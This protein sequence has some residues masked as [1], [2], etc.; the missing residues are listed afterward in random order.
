M[1]DQSRRPGTLWILAVVVV[2][3]AVVGGL[4]QPG[5]G[6]EQAF[7]ADSGEQA[8]GTEAGPA[9][10]VVT[11]EIQTIAP[12]SG[13]LTGGDIVTITGTDLDRVV[14]S[15]GSSPDSGVFFGGSNGVG[16]RA[17]RMIEKTAT[18]LTVIA[19]RGAAVGAA[20]VTLVTGDLLVTRQGGY[21]YLQPTITSVTPSSG[22]T[23]G[24][25]AVTIE[26]TGFGYTGR[27][28]ADSTIT[29]VTVG[30][31]PA[32]SVVRVDATTITA[33]VPAHVAATT[34]VVVTVSPSVGPQIVITGSGLFTYV[35]AP[36]APTISSVTPASGPTAGGNTVLVTGTNLRGSDT[37]PA[38][39]SFGGTT[40]TVTAVNVEKTQATVTVP[41]HAAGLVD[42]VARTSDG[43]ATLISGYE[44]GAPPTITSI[45]P[46]SGPLAG[47]TRITVTGTNFGSTGVPA[48][49]VG[50]RA[51]RCVERVSS[52]RILAV[53]PVG[54][55]GPAD[56]VVS[57]ATGGGKATR[58]G[59][60]TYVVPT[61]TPTISAITPPQGPYTG[62]TPIT[63]T[64]TNF[65]SATTPTVL[66][67]GQCAT[68]VV[69][70]SNT[71]ITAKTPAGA[72]G[73]ATLQVTTA[74][75][76]VTSNLF[77]YVSITSVSPVSG[78]TT[79]DTTITITGT[80]F[81]VSPA[82]TVGGAAATV[83][84]ASPTSIVAVTPPGT[85]GPRDVV[86]TP[87]GGV[88]ITRAEGFR[89]LAPTI[90]SVRP[91]SGLLSGGNTV[92]VT[93][94]GFGSTGTPSV[95]FGGRAATNVVRLGSTSLTATVPAGAA[96]V[97]V[98]VVVTPTRGVGSG[99]LSDGYAY[100]ALQRTP[101]I[102]DVSPDRGSQE[103]GTVV[104]VEGW[105][106]RGSND[107]PARVT[108]GGVSVL[109][110]SV[111]AD[112]RSL[113]FTAPVTTAG[114]KNLSII[115]NEGTATLFGAFASVG[116]PTISG[117]D[118]VSPRGAITYTG[119]NVITIDGSGFRDD[120]VPPP[121]VTVNGTAAVVNSSTDTRI[122][123]TIP[124]VSPGSL[125]IT[126]TPSDGP[127]TTL[128]ACI[129]LQRL[130][131]I[132]AVASPSS[133][134]YD[135]PTA[136]FSFTTA[137]LQSG[138]GVGS[139][140]FAFSGTGSTAYGPS[141]NPPTAS[142]TYEVMPSAAV[143]SSGSASNYTIVYVPA[144]YTIA[145]IGAT[146]T[147]DDKEI[148]YGDP[149]PTFTGFATG[150]EG[151]DALDEV[152]Y[153]FSGSGYGPS[154]TP[155]TNAGVYTITPSVVSL[156]P[157][158]VANYSFVP[159]VGTYT[160]AK[161]PVTVTPDSGQTKVYDGSVPDPDTLTYAIT[162][163]SL[164]GTDTLSD[165]LKV[166][167]TGVGSYEIVKSDLAD[168]S[169][170]NYDITV[171]PGVQ[172]E[173]TPRPVTVTP[174]SKTKVY[175]DADPTLT[176]TVSPS[177]SLSGAVTRTDGEAVG[178]Y[179]ITQGTLTN[180]NNPN[181]DITFTTGVNLDITKRPITITSDD[182]EIT[183]GDTLPVNG[184]SV[185]TGSLAFLDVLTSATY[186]Y[187]PLDPVDAGEYTIT[188]SEA[189]ITG[190]TGGADNYDITYVGSTLTI[191]PVIVTVTPDDNQSKVYDDV[192]PTLTYTTSTLPDGVTITGL[193][194]RDSGEDVD[195]YDFTLGTLTT[196]DGNV[197][198]ELADPSPTF[199]I[200]PLAVTVTA[201]AKTKDYGSDDPALTYSTSPTVT[202]SGSL[203]RDTGESVG[204]Y[205]ITQ[206][207]VT[208]ANN[209]NY[210][211]TFVG[212]DLTITP[213]TVTV[214]PDAGQSKVYG[215]TDPA[216]T[217]TTSPD[218]PLTGDLSR[219]TG[220]NVGTYA[221]TQ[222]TLVSTADYTITFSSGSTFEVTARPITI[223]A[224]D[225]SSTF[226][227]AL[228]GNSATVTSGTLASGDSV[229][230]LDYA[231]SPV[232]TPS[233]AGTYDITPSAAVITP[234][235]ESNYDV[236]YAD[237]TL[238]IDPAIVTV[239]PDPDQTKVFGDT[240]PTLTY[241]TSPTQSLT[242][243][244]GRD[245]GEDVGEYDFTLGT[246]SV[247]PNYELELADPSPTFGVTPLAVTV[248]ADPQTKSYGDTDPT[249]GYTTDPDVGTALSG[250][251]DRDPGED[252]GTYPITQ[253]TV[254][255]ENN[256]NYTVTFVS[257]GL[258]ITQAAVTVTPDAGQTKIYG[259]D[260]PTLT[261]VADPDV[262]LDGE[263]DRDPGEDVD[264]YD[265]TQGTIVS[266]ANYTVTFASGATFEIVPRPVT[267]TADDQEAAVGESL[268]T[269]TS[270]ITS[271]DLATGDT[272]G[273]VTYT[274]TP[275]DPAAIGTYDIVPSGATITPG[276]ASNYDITYVAGTLTI[277]TAAVTVTAA[278]VTVPYGVD[279]GDFT[280]SATGL[281]D[282]DELGDVTYQFSGSGYG[283]STTPPT[284]PGVYDIDPTVDSLDPGDLADYTITTETGTL[285]ITPPEV[286]GLLPDRGTYLGGTPFILTGS[287]FGPDGAVPVVT[288]GGVP[289]DGVIRVDNRTLSGVTP[290]FTLAEEFTAE[291]VD[292]EV[293]L[294][295]EVSG[296]LIDAYTYLPPRQTPV[297][298]TLF[299]DEGPTAGGT[300]LTITGEHLAGSDG[301]TPVVF[302]DG[303]LSP[304]VTVGDD[305]SFVEAVTPPGPEGEP[306]DVE[307]FTN[308][309]G[310]AFLS[311]YTY[312]PPTIDSVSPARGYTVGGTTVVVTGSGFGTS[313]PVVE[314][315]GARARVLEHSPTS[316]TIVTPPGEV[317]PADVTVS[318]VGDPE[319]VTRAGAFT[320]VV[321]PEGDVSG[322][323]WLDLDGD[324]VYDRDTE[325][326]FPGLP[327]ELEL[328]QY[329]LP[330]LPESMVRGTNA[331]SKGVG[332]AASVDP[333][334]VPGD[335]PPAAGVT[336]SNG[337]YE[338][339]SLPFGR[340]RLTFTLPSDISPTYL[341]PGSRNG[342]LEFVISAPG[343][344]AD[345]GG[346]GR[347]SLFA[348]VANESRQ[349]FRN[350]DV[351][352]R[353][354]GPD[355][356]MDTEDDVVIPT[357]SNGDGQV[358][359][360]RRLPGGQY[361]AERINDRGGLEKS[362][363]LMLR[364]DSTLS[365]EWFI[366]PG[367]STPD[368][369]T[370]GVL[371]STGAGRVMSLL[372]VATL[373]LSGGA[374]L[375]GPVVRRRRGL[376]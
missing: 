36:A 58:T 331:M 37:N 78:P 7:A 260:D 286:G 303:S 176:Y 203:D 109:N 24:G 246:L 55:L 227:D 1:R 60:F 188:P 324:G 136:T 328:V 314:V 291:L 282:G 213:V 9:A 167:G 250:T 154:T 318:P 3:L 329:E 351:D 65:A 297:M 63:I 323:L 119:S 110:L 315:G 280:S 30:G 145:G 340:Y 86:V 374:V 186:G 21:R 43:Q 231:Y 361:R 207:T 82:V 157:G 161:R 20:D 193:L 205:P 163:G 284:A 202:L 118:A 179:E 132:T 267:L 238:T 278:D 249:L 4:P 264:T 219:D 175:G 28:F 363:T 240:D 156:D 75:G 325:P 341:P 266:N 166:V 292:V 47:G 173:I 152:S 255:T 143:F 5:S 29:S 148:T 232:T 302:V 265:I 101:L 106:F 245:S 112:G 304:E 358:E 307:L 344:V 15:P 294:D 332:S 273:T 357:R 153:S 253:G 212:A 241:T 162:L 263:L 226:G 208:D 16:G 18:S 92:T 342:V 335:R 247:D 79:G 354:W 53:V 222:G 216:L 370:P 364:A 308:E 217:Y 76:S 144:S 275:A 168:A 233:D 91:A 114:D 180:E 138:D 178:S 211:I 366:F 95:T 117:C 66:V 96:L 108:L 229:D 90:T 44:Y 306:R 322:V 197:S 26:G 269:N 184:A 312:I 254:T 309:G 360:V 320:Y 42:V 237:G 251:L 346:V 40:A 170:P 50:G 129:A 362:T 165:V 279:P 367:T 61:T 234:G 172:F 33:R 283:P 130:L 214:T 326:P 330:P 69:V 339:Q 204:T 305:G 259:D 10:V 13:P 99:T 171:T 31:A 285:T 97:S 365:G 334:I 8:P 298:R 310:V 83:L 122:T 88:P 191:N 98:D 293:L 128:S 103:G 313:T 126:V 137:G 41:A 296:S 133:I 276:G 74:T 32:T 225:Q 87:A 120:G 244:L 140:S 187:S 46:A 268:P 224:D 182:R 147:A 196:G 89:Y 185:T 56:V 223:T 160:I 111:A 177:Y 221:I 348:F 195:D 350:T 356:A 150:L 299:P 295:G 121:T 201:D 372:L 84:S 228:P 127:G 192:D 124:Q 49:L 274:Y 2:L 300:V 281:A 77:S 215:D 25:Q 194:G 64:G 72:T 333:V 27:G 220:E 6:V 287:G 38:A 113:T 355:R 345:A 80:G 239:T 14:G 321:T 319:Q 17:A 149:A 218:V 338:Y 301:G 242:G 337:R 116:P 190:T 257:D 206:G 235:G 369:E 155:P 352:L 104:T 134:T 81:G 199:A 67:N 375:C 107:V 290:P 270:Q 288:F 289:A 158:N 200:T 115:T 359:F 123:F 230:S 373:L 164:V 39:I 22:A 317:G 376:R 73:T 349:V 189:V 210:D 272:L 35:L 71:S 169:N 93:G 316:L 100:A 243:D 94:T 52:T 131:T 252:V 353:W 174:A 277:T 262:P 102:D 343:L 371:P 159:V 34:D 146:I 105:N 57:P 336:G 256:P 59:G 236:T 368:P 85:T 181:F 125:T 12:A 142:G 19:P 48:V 11:P 62:G 23:S 139:V 327:V 68:D 311:S 209:G 258:E 151:G 183:Y 198:L 70:A 45:S 347:S 271:G 135:D 248:T 51:A 54:D 261:Y 141:A